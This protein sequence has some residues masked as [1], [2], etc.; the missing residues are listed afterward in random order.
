MTTAA[1][2]GRLSA[3]AP[4]PP[5]RGRLLLACWLISIVVGVVVVIVAGGMLCE[6]YFLSRGIHR[7]SG[8]LVP[9]A[10]SIEHHTADIA[11]LRRTDDDAVS[12]AAS[13]QP[14]AS[15]VSRI[16]DQVTSIIAAVG[17]IDGGLPGVAGNATAID[18]SV[19]GIASSTN[20]IA[21][22]A[23]SIE[24]GLSTTIADLQLLL[25]R[26]QAVESDAGALITRPLLPSILDHATSIDCKIPGIGRGDCP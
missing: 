3:A 17:Q 22:S 25:G 16:H 1:Q 23:R 7:S 6:A 5:R 8:P 26:I 14:L 9:V 4:R 12:I 15:T 24:T 19:S 2:A 11:D 13:V 18:Q 21:R 20:A 10:A